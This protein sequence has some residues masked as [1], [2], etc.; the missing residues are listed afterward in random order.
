MLNDIILAR[1]IRRGDIKSF[2]KVFRQF[3]TPLLYFATGITGRRDVSE[4]IIQELF[5]QIWRDRETLN[6]RSSL[7]G[8]LYTSVKNSSLQYCRRE[9][10]GEQ[11]SQA[12]KANTE[13]DSDPLNEV[14]YKEMEGFVF[15]ALARMPARRSQIFKM[16]RFEGKKYSEIA[17]VFSL[18]LK[19]IEAEMSRAIKQ[20][21]KEIEK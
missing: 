6:V 18:S 11:F 13:F 10:L 1:G 20:L 8:Y 5:Y 16:H 3:F 17:N 4:E 12:F 15:R 2:E 14:E 19:T 9:K 7:R 21:R